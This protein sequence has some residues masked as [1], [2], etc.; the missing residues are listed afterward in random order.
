M[1]IQEKIEILIRQWAAV[2]LFGFMKDLGVDHKLAV[3]NVYSSAGYMQNSKFALYFK[4]I[5]EKFDELS[6][7]DI[8]LHQKVLE[9]HINHLAD[10]ETRNFITSSIAVAIQHII[11]WGVRTLKPGK[12]VRRER[13]NGRSGLHIPK[14][15]YNYIINLL[16]YLGTFIKQ[17]PVVELA[18]LDHSIFDLL[19][20]VLLKRKKGN[21]TEGIIINLMTVNSAISSQI[22]EMI[23]SI[24]QQKLEPKV[25]NS[26]NLITTGVDYFREA[27]RDT[28]TNM[29]QILTQLKGKWSLQPVASLI[30]KT[31]YFINENSPE[32]QYI[33]SYITLFYANLAK[34]ALDSPSEDWFTLLFQLT[35]IANETEI[36]PLAQKFSHSLNKNY[37][38]LGGMV[39]FRLIGLYLDSLIGKPAT[40]S[41]VVK[42]FLGKWFD[43]TSNFTSTYA[44]DTDYWMQIASKIHFCAPDHFKEFATPIIQ[45]GESHP[46]YTRIVQT[47]QI[48]ICITKENMGGLTSM[49]APVVTEMCN[50]QDIPPNTLKLFAP[51]LSILWQN[52]TNM[53]GLITSLMSR[54]IKSNDITVLTH[55]S[56]FFT[57]IMENYP[58]GTMPINLITTFAI[59][60]LKRTEM[61]ISSQQ[62]NSVFNIYHAFF[63][64]IL[65]Y[66]KRGDNVVDQEQFIRVLKATE[67]KLIMFS[68]FPAQNILDT[69]QDIWEMM[70]SDSITSIAPNA[71]TLANLIPNIAQIDL[72]A[73]IKILIQEGIEQRITSLIMM[74]NSADNH[75]KEFRVRLAKFLYILCRHEYFVNNENLMQQGVSKMLKVLSTLPRQE[76]INIT[77]M[78]PFDVWSMYIEILKNI[79]DLDI[80]NKL[81]IPYAM[82]CNKNFKKA[83]NENRT[84]TDLLIQ[85]LKAFIVSPAPRNEDEQQADV[86]ASEF[87]ATLVR[88]SSEYLTNSEEFHDVYQHIN[89]IIARLNPDSIT[90]PD[91]SHVY[92]MLELVHAFVTTWRLSDQ[93]IEDLIDWTTFIAL[94]TKG[95]V[96]LQA[97]CHELLQTI[98]MMNQ[99]GMAVII[100]S[101]FRTSIYTTAHVAAAIA[102]SNINPLYQAVLA[103]GLC[104]RPNIVCRA[105]AAEIANNVAEGK[106]HPM[107]YLEADF[108]DQIVAHFSQFL[109]NDSRDFVF[110]LLPEVVGNTAAN[111]TILPHFQFIASRFR[112]ITSIEQIE[113][114]LKFTAITDFTDLTPIKPLLPIWDIIFKNPPVK[115]QDI[116][117]M[118]LS[119]FVSVNESKQLCAVCIAFQRA[120]LQQSKVTAQFLTSKLRIIQDPKMTFDNFTPT[121]SELA[122]SACMS[123]IFSLEIDVQRFNVCWMDKIQYILAWAIFLRFNPLYE[124]HMIPPLLISVSHAAVPS[125]DLPLFVM[126]PSECVANAVVL[127]FRYTTEFTIPQMELLLATLKKFSLLTAELFLD[128]CADKAT[129]LTKYSADFWTL[130]SNFFQPRHSSAFLNN[131]MNSATAGDLETV[132]RMLPILTGVVR[133]NARAEHIGGFVDV[134]IF[135]ISTTG[136]L[137]FLKL[138]T[139]HLP[140]FVEAVQ[141]SS[142]A[143]TITSTLD[144]V[145]KEHGGEQAVVE[146]VIKTLASADSFMSPNFSASLTFLLEVGSL[147]AI[148]D[149]KYSL[150]SAILFLFDSIRRIE[151]KGLSLMISQ[152][153]LGIDPPSNYNDLIEI[154][155]KYWTG[156]QVSYIMSYLQAWAA[157]TMMED[158]PANALT[159][160]RIITSDWTDNKHILNPAC[161]SVAI[162]HML[163]GATDENY[164]SL[165]SDNAKIIRTLVKEEKEFPDISAIVAPLISPRKGFKIADPKS[166]PPILPQREHYA[167]LGEVCEFI[168]NNILE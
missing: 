59:Q 28:L 152:P 131:F 81:K 76:L 93:V 110:T 51:L 50:Q 8:R 37:S 102:I 91:I 130:F 26:L 38:K 159:M 22:W 149:T 101:C 146:G 72:N 113:Q 168:K 17:I 29:V 151:T 90:L 15:G 85:L 53:H 154:L 66:A 16:D 34:Y 65:I 163:I 119:K 33:S 118:L 74:F 18:T 2:S 137:Q 127:P 19:L 77:T 79:K 1:N 27:S 167:T 129:S 158:V 112:T 39:Y 73:L 136:D 145:I 23:S 62:I 13:T 64:S 122:A 139:K 157:T 25:Q 12:E 80:R 99:E 150:T 70:R 161:L 108:E 95:S 11:I 125:S 20:N 57:D 100:K 36:A 89:S 43:K 88:A 164:R 48:I 155:K 9:L 97:K 21:G 40:A 96:L 10:D 166:L 147:L 128:V 52:E 46:L 106:F 133:Q 68:F 126:K 56:T 103:L 82:S 41:E 32:K 84:L 75:L 138:I 156:P 92:A 49:I 24:A 42:Y 135:V 121:A 120:F 114:L 132:G 67:N 115:I 58:V 94:K 54:F 83:V 109:D 5:P 160:L 86:S 142:E 47:I 87:C 71:K 117:E 116:F 165:S 44:N 148:S 141:L 107:A 153:L 143:S 78:L 63:R 60:F 123:Y 7:E 69:V 140:G 45:A 162:A 31:F 61:D 144:W 98:I 14:Q 55:A 30:T 104:S 35:K 111:G 105:I 4:Q 6:Q 124:S 3:E 134:I